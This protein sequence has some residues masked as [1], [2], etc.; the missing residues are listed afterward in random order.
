MKNMYK[1]ILVGFLAFMALDASVMEN[2][3][4][5]VKKQ[6]LQNA[7]NYLESATKKT[8]NPERK[9]NPIECCQLVDF[10]TKINLS[11]VNPEA[12]T[13]AAKNAEV[14]ELAENV[15][16]INTLIIKDIDK[17]MT[18]GIGTGTLISLLSTEKREWLEALEKKNS[19]DGSA[20][21]EFIKKMKEIFNQNYN[22]NYKQLKLENYL[23]YDF[24]KCRC[25]T[26]NTPDDLEKILRDDGGENLRALQ[27]LKS[28]D[29]K[30]VLTCAHCLTNEVSL[31]NS[32]SLDKGINI[33]GG[34]LPLNKNNTTAYLSVTPF[35]QFNSGKFVE[36][37][38]SVDKHNENRYKVNKAYIGSGDIALLILDNPVA[39]TN[40]ISIFDLEMDVNDDWN[41]AMKETNTPDGYMDFV[42]GFGWTGGASQEFVGW[43]DL[44]MFMDNQEQDIRDNAEN[45]AK[46][47]GWNSPKLVD[48]SIK[49]DDNMKQGYI[50]DSLLKYSTTEMAGEGF[51]GS[52]IVRKEKNI[53]KNVDKKIK[54][55]V[56]LYS[57]GNNAGSIT[58][59]VATTIEKLQK[60]LSKQ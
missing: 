11:Y 40:G 42:I 1:S 23:L 48:L 15:V 51:S 32:L 12:Q 46:Y 29:G 50:K 19:G 20:L 49:Y 4:P 47:L 35:D 16:R 30:L 17:T 41:G 26:L 34:R 45:L 39:S 54:T 37:V 24:S 38:Y 43:K 31:V 44:E 21:R 22:P 3:A 58:N 53:D 14:R 8:V 33:E 57:S 25:Y 55:L 52:L 27:H 9:K 7:I 56:G 6:K 28:F 13:E 2:S 18:G 60:E 36:L 5:E 59:F 10:S